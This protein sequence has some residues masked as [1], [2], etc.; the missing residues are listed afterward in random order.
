MQYSPK[1]KKA[2]EEIKEVLNKHDIAG[3]VIL[4]T[5]GF[6]EYLNHVTTSYSC[7]QVTPEGV[8]LRLKG[9]EVGKEKAQQL[10]LDT[11]NMIVHFAKHLAANA[12]FYMDTEE[13][14]RQRWGGEDLDGSG[15]TS[16]EQQNN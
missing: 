12:M 7:A 6:S 16:H 5:P 14:L 10:A 2:I 13:N 9:S 3:F 8:R 1:L 11:F 15:H 4:H